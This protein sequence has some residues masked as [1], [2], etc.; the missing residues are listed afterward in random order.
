M[1]EY[2]IYGYF[3]DIDPHAPS[4]KNVTGRKFECCDQW[5]YYRKAIDD[6]GKVFYEVTMPCNGFR[7]G[8]FDR[9]KDA[10]EFITSNFEAIV[11]KCETKDMINAERRFQELV[12]EAKENENKS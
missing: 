2:Y 3:K 6:R 8:G 11:A 4:V 10:K 5:W 12:A 7:I 1:I 9:L